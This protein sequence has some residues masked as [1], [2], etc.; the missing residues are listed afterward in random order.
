MF[1]RARFKLCLLFRKRLKEH[2]LS[3]YLSNYLHLST[4]C[5]MLQHMHILTQYFFGLCVVS[6]ARPLQCPGAEMENVKLLQNYKDATEIHQI[7]SGKR[8]I[9]VGTSFIGIQ[10]TNVKFFYTHSS[11]KLCI[12]IFFIR[13]GG[14]SLF[15][16]Q[17][18]QCH[19]YWQQ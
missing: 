1:W 7:S 9:I 10:K 11:V 4:F 2:L 19:C 8:A 5:K 14:S 15:V 6:R 16:W 3:H 17:G 13:N 12:L 18:I